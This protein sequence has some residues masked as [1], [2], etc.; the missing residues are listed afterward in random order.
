M[1]YKSCVIL[2]ALAALLAAVA[3]AQFDPFRPRRSRQRD[4]RPEMV[5]RNG[6]PVWSNDE[7]FKADLFTFARAKY[8]SYGW[9]GGKWATDYPDS[10]LNFSYRLKELTAL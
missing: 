4:F 2:A 5:D 6:V 9:G 3:V 1:K 8:S 7:R 10:D